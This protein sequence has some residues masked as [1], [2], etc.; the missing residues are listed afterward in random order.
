MVILHT[1]DNSIQ[2]Y[3][4]DARAQGMD[5]GKIR[6][7]LLG[8]GWSVEAIDQVLGTRFP[9]RKLTL[10]LVATLIMA[11]GAAGFWYYQRSHPNT[12][13]ASFDSIVIAAQKE[14]YKKVRKYI[15]S[16]DL[17]NLDAKSIEYTANYYGADIAEISQ[18]FLAHL[19]L[20]NDVPVDTRLK[21]TID[22]AIGGKNELL[23]ARLAP[24]ENLSQGAIC[25]LPFIQE[26]GIWKLRI[27]KM[28]CN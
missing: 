3:I 12:P 19:S 18:K 17:N 26:N 4:N 25:M 24:T 28:F 14:D 9:R 7:A 20:N 6:E 10:I 21:E 1:M 27:S 5:D 2:E 22:Q 13:R 8:S 15:S 16:E 11:A 23:L